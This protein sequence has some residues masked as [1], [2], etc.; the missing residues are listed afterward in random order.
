MKT[1]KIVLFHLIGLFVILCLHSLVFLK[2]YGTEYRHYYSED[3]DD[4]DETFYEDTI[5]QVE[6][7][8]DSTYKVVTD[9]I[10][11]IYKVKTGAKISTLSKPYEPITCMAMHP[12]GSHLLILDQYSVNVYDLI[13]DNLAN[14]ETTLDYEEDTKTTVWLDDLSSADV[15]NVDAIA[16]SADR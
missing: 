11:T 8:Q 3:Y 2:H 12:S 15:T 6:Y 7:L 1:L 14:Q 13:K 16:F 5:P 10:I 4:D 9:T